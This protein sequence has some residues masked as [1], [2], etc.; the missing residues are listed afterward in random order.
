[1]LAGKALH[2][3]FFLAQNGGTYSM[4][5]VIPARIIGY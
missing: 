5:L 4:D 2:A 3:T 1:M